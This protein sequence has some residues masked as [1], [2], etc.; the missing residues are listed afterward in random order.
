VLSREAFPLTPEIAAGI[1][2]V[3]DLFVFVEVFS[4]R[5]EILESGDPVPMARDAIAAAARGNAP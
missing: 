5:P 4:V 2:G 3:L 1:V